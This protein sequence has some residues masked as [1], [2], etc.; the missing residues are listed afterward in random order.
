MKA[1]QRANINAFISSIIW[2]LVMGFA[3]RTF[4]Q[5]IPVSRGADIIWYGGNFLALM[6]YP[7]LVSLILR[8]KINLWIN[9]CFFSLIGG[10]YSV[11]LMYSV[12]AFLLKAW[13]YVGYGVFGLGF[14]GYMLMSRAG[15]MYA[16]Q[17]EWNSPLWE[18]LNLSSFE[19]FLLLRFDMINSNAG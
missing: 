13:M 16:I 1:L 15:N 11:V 19:E 8:R 7:I 14:I 2:G 4:R 17:E 6:L 5:I 18:K 3:I 9:I 10:L 12:D